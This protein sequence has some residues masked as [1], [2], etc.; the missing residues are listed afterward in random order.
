M[1]LIPRA[2]RKRAL[3]TWLNSPPT[4]SI[5]DKT[6]EFLLQ[7]WTDKWWKEGGHKKVLNRLVSDD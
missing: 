1:S 5:E 2:L 7:R 4:I 6:K 3:V